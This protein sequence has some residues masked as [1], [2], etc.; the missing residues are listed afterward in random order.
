[1]VA[2]T[3]TR[4]NGDPVATARVRVDLSMPSCSDGLNTFSSTTTDAL[5]RYAV[6]LD[7]PGSVG[8]CIRVRASISGAEPIIVEKS[9]LDPA[10]GRPPADTTWIDV[11]FP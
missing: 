6:N 5:G 8:S 2:G 11:E 9:G 1:M 3:V 4:A 10:S 7:Y